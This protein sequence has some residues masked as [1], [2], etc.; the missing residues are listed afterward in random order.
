MKIGRFILCARFTTFNVLYCQDILTFTPLCWFDQ[1]YGFCCSC[2]QC[3]PG[4]LVCGMQLPFD[5]VHESPNIK[6]RYIKKSSKSNPPLPLKI[7]FRKILYMPKKKPKQYSKWIF[8]LCMSD[9][10]F[11]IWMCFYHWI[12]ETYWKKMNQVCHTGERIG[13]LLELSYT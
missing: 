7:V 9:N 10:V 5:Q 12:L 6:H 8:G 13:N 2:E 1:R 4:P 3:G 11:C